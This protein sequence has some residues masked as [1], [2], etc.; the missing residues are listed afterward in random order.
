MECLATFVVL[1]VLPLAVVALVVALRAQRAARGAVEE[2]AL[3]KLTVA[4]LSRRLQ[5]LSAAERAAEAAPGARAEE[6]KPEVAASVVAPEVVAPEA[7]GAPRVDEVAAIEAV[8]PAE[9]S[10]AAAAEPTWPRTPPPTRPAP[11]VTPPNLGQPP[12]PAASLEERLGARLPVWIGAIALV[13]AAAFLLK[14]SVDQGWIG[15]T[16]RVTLGALFGVA[17]LAGGEL[18]RR[19][20]AFVAQGLTAAGIAVL[21]VVELAALHLYHLIGPTT[22]FA[23]LAL[24]T[25]TAVSLA[26]RHGVMVALVGLVG[27]FLTPVLVSTGHPNAT[28]LF[29]YLALLQAGLLAVSRRRGWSALAGLS[30][31]AALV[32]ACGWAVSSY[33]ERDAMAIGLFLV[34]TVAA[35]LVASLGRGERWGAPLASW[36][37]AGAAG[38]AL[39]V[40]SVLAVQT[41][42]GLVEWGFVGLLAAGCLVLGRRSAELEGLAWLAAG[43]ICLIFGAWAEH[44]QP[45]V[46]TRFFGVAGGA[47]LLLGGGSWAAK[48]GSQSPARWASLAALATLAVDLIAYRG[49]RIADLELPWGWIELGLAAIWVVLA[50]PVAREREATAGGEATLAAAAAIATTLVSLAVPMELEHQ[51][52]SVGWALEVAALV[53][54]AG[55]LR[56]PLLAHLAAL[57]TALVGVRLLLNP[58]VVDYPTGTHPIFSW[59]LYGYGIPI[60]AFAGATVMARRQGRRPLAAGVGA[61]AVALTVVFLALAVHQAFSPGAPRNEPTFAELGSLTILWLLLA[62][63]LLA[64]AARV[65]QPTT[66]GVVGDADPPPAESHPCPELRWGG[67][68]VACLAIA[69]AFLT[70]ALVWNPVLRH[71]PVGAPR[72]FND[73]M[74][75]YGLPA[76]LLLGAVALERRAEVAW[77]PRWPWLPRLWS[78]AALLLL[79]LLVTLE[80]RQAFRGPYLDAGAATVAEQYAYSAAWILLATSL[81][82]AGLLRKQRSLRLASLPVML[83]AV[84]KVFLYDTANLSDLY[85]VF[86]FLGLGVSLLLLAWLYQRFVFRSTPEVP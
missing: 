36:V 19:S 7:A 85:R 53:W 4:E 67:I 35:I 42:Y 79:F 69:Q 66:A 34:A 84:G 33:A 70:Q 23:L 63:G 21:F 74:I 45:D 32:W 80:V 61:V 9:P 13:L 59:L 15:P 49:A 71:I 51:W 72:V 10:A 39:V 17:L 65:A 68:A 47:L 73:L 78:V 86:S 24:T 14:Y 28:L 37:R 30:T 2:A 31:T 44:L 29:A 3:L 50:L 46:A 25:A 57:L 22:G 48:R 56:V 41:D 58:A 1:V 62:C 5:K 55:R 75:A 64:T 43:A 26:L 81:L 38:G 77:S 52:I 40:S 11:P 6:R 18:L 16:V 20:S 12:R 8:A 83:L 60:A 54:L 27:G 76:A 82:V